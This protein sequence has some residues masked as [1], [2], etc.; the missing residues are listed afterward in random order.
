MAPVYPTAR[1]GRPERGAR[2]G[3]KD[4][5]VRGPWSVAP[6]PAPSPPPSPTPAPGPPLPG[7]GWT[8]GSTPAVG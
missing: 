2:G 8:D 1:A 7:W 4:T 6:I 3:G 5:V